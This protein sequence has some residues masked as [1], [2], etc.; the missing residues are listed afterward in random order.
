MVTIAF[1]YSVVKK[2]TCYEC[3]TICG[4]PQADNR[5]LGLESSLQRSETFKTSKGHRSTKFS[6]EQSQH[7]FGDDII[8]GNINIVEEE[9]AAILVF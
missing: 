9:E 1:R 3:V 6:F 4:N 8:V 2:H 5:G 7:T